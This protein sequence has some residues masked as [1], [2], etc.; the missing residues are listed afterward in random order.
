MNERRILA[1][2]PRLG[3]PSRGQAFPGYVDANW[4]EVGL[5]WQLN[6]RF[7]GASAAAKAGSVAAVDAP[8]FGVAHRLLTGRLRAHRVTKG[9]RAGV[10]VDGIHLTVLPHKAAALCRA[11]VNIGVARDRGV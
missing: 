2:A 6:G 9:Q 11:H 1:P 5:H 8:F 10:T 4:K 7:S 3:E